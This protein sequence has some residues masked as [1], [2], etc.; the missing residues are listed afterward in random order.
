M[1]AV[2]P[3]K[4]STNHELC[5]GSG[6]DLGDEVAPEEV[7]IGA[8]C[9]FVVKDLGSLLWRSVGA[10]MGKKSYGRIWFCCSKATSLITK[11]VDRRHRRV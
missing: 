6:T 1:P 2:A 11:P 10:S 4:V 9:A 7:L 5:V 3:A 8:G